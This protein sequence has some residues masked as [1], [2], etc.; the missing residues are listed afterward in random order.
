M[1]DHVYLLC[2]YPMQ[3]TAICTSLPE[4]RR[5]AQIILFMGPAAW[6]GGT[7]LEERKKVLQEALLDDPSSA[8]NIALSEVRENE[9][10][11][12]AILPEKEYI[13]SVHKVSTNTVLIPEVW[14]PRGVR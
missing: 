14:E 6:D 1:S 9:F 4:V 10:E 12:F 2:L 3:I 11:A 13:G 5:V 8:P 7:N